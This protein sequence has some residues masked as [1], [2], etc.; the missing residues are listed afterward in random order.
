MSAFKYSHAPNEL[1]IKRV[2]APNIDISAGICWCQCRLHPL[3]FHPIEDRLKRERKKVRPIFKKNMN[4]GNLVQ[5]K[6]KCKINCK[7]ERNTADIKFQ[8]SKN[9]D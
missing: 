5:L 2:L 8:P 1:T 4:K 3:L 6:V 7:S 9:L